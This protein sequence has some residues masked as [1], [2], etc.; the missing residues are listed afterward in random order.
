MAK[1]FDPRKIL[2]QI[3][4]PLLRDFFE[5]RGELLDVP[6]DDLTEHKIEPVFEAWQAL[7]EESLKQI[8]VILRDINELA[9]QRGLSVLAEEIRWR[10]V[11]RA[12]E[13]RRQTSKADKAMWVYLHVREAFEQAALFARADA[14]SVGRYWN[15]RNGL[16]KQPL[17][18][19]AQACA[20][21]S[22]KL[23]DFYGPTQLRG[24]HCHIAHY[25]RSV[26]GD[27]FFAYLDD[28]P[29]THIV[30]DDNSDQPKVRS[31]RYAFENVFVYDRDDGSLEMFAQGG[32]KV[33]EPLQTAFCEAVLGVQISPADP[34]R[35][36]FALDHLL[37]SSFP[38]TTQPADGV[39]DA[40]ITR[41]RLSPPGSAGYVEVKAD[42][43][44]D[45]D[46]I[47]RKVDRWLKTERFPLETTNVRQATF[48]LTF[49][50]DG[51]GR[52]PTLTFDVSVPHSSN[53]KSK[54]DE[55]RVIGERCLKLW[56]V[57]NDDDE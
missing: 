6:W 57:V 10:C 5:R 11:D 31:D 45:R 35:P 47:Y 43:K 38:L 49:Q 12:E 53:L 54:P 55:Q 22:G 25:R 14:L 20:R 41:L 40:R 4:N 29:D 46:D 24:R 8:Q 2:K 32:K 26:G 9:D 50:H 28:Y 17:D 27:Y 44:G 42:P 18:D 33:W 52:Q 15:R 30:F 1:P 19:E 13:F 23:T 37:D 48:R 3:A 36:S 21:L 56:K 39:E 7:P 34:M 16:P 51:P